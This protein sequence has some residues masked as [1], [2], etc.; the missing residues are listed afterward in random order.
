[1]G[2]DED[3]ADVDG[4]GGGREYPVG[5]GH[6][7]W[8]HGA[9]GLA[10]AAVALCLL[11]AFVLTEGPRGLVGA[12]SA[13]TED[14]AP[15]WVPAW[16][17]AAQPVPAGPV[18][19]GATL[20]MVVTPQVTGSQVRV[21]LSNAYGTTPLQVGTVSVGRSA[22]GA[23]LLP[24]TMTPVAFGGRPDAS[25]PAG[26]DLVSDPV[27]LVAEAGRPLAVSMFTPVLPAVLTGHGV[28][29]QAS[30][31]SAPGDAALATDGAAYGTEVGSWMV[32][33]GVEVLAPRPVNT[34]VTIG[35]SITDGVGAGPGE[36]WPDALAQQLSGPATMSVLNAGIS[37]NRLLAADP[38]G[39]DPPA[40]RFARDVPGA[41]DVVL[42]I[43]TNDIAAGAGAEEIVD[44]LVAFA[45]QARAAG[46]RVLLTTITPSAHGPHGTP[47]AVATRAAVNAW[48]LEDGREH[49][50]GVVDFAAAVADPAD[51]TRLA[52]AYDSG[53]GLHLSAT[54]YRELAAA[55]DPALLTGSPCLADTT[56]SR[57][58]VSDR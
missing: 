52:A 39:G 13:S 38:L 1:M 18:P 23:G 10:A 22:G 8:G 45:A 19:A 40:T 20:R 25:I 49:A 35:D 27:G 47:E 4:V 24:G 5:W 44:G 32:L 34:V 7:R 30:Y 33:S 26:A 6:V 17:A 42:H 55:V 53:D 43:G 14:C 12:A 41:S 48:V 29:L 16:H 3:S 31:V 46:S 15:A 50:D 21:R 2:G 11:G 57:V 28:A 51:P 36:R 58:L 54:G 37:R 56:P 9:R